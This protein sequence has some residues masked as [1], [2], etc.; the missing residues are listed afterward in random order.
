MGSSTWSEQSGHRKRRKYVRNACVNC[1]L[2]KVKCSGEPNCSQCQADA[3]QCEYPAS[4]KR[5]KPAGDGVS[6]PGQGQDGAHTAQE[7]ELAKIMARI[8]DLE[9]NYSI[10]CSQMDSSPPQGRS[11]GTISDVQDSN[12]SPCTDSTFATLADRDGWRGSTSFVAQLSTLN[13]SLAR[14]PL[15]QG[16]SRAESRATSPPDVTWSNLP[17][18]TEMTLTAVERETRLNGLAGIRQSVDTFFFYLNTHYPCINENSF[19]SL[20]EKFLADEELHELSYA[21]RQQF[22]ALVNLVHAEVRMLSEEWTSSARAPAWEAFCRAESILGR[23]TW[24]GNGNLLTIQCLLIKARY[25]LYAEK[26]HGAYDTMGR[27]VRLC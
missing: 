23:L 18:S 19:R 3:V 25:L 5:R 27:V 20:F 7:Q 9:A 17:R 10:L 15:P 2:R 22:I 11:L 13:R 4:Q 26:A 16:D 14:E 24:L 12:P 6:P 8:R 21:D 1:R